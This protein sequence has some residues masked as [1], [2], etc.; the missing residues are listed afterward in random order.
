[1]SGMG[2]FFEGLSE[3]GIGWLFIGV[4]GVA[5]YD[6]IV[7]GLTS[8]VRR[9]RLQGRLSARRSGSDKKVL[10]KLPDGGKLELTGLSEK[11]I[12]DVLE[13]VAAPDR[14]GTERR[15]R[16]AVER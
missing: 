14:A 1:M 8:I 4:V 9:Q 16:E 5:L 6:P 12:R 7:G 10:V 3:N 11:Q 13:Q 2:S 15:V